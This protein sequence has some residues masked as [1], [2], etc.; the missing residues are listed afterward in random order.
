MLKVEVVPLDMADIVAE[1]LERLAPMIEEYRAEIILPDAW[2]AALG[3]GPWVVEVWANYVSN[4][5]KYGGTPPRVELG[6]TAQTDGTV[7][8]WVRDNGLGLS[9][10]EQGR[11]FTPFTRL[12]QDRGQGQTEVSAHRHDQGGEDQYVEMGEKMNGRGEEEYLPFLWVH[13]S[14]R[15]NVKAVPPIIDRLDGTGEGGI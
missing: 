8:F 12:H 4:A 15:C 3:Y 1:A 10:E 6:A 2:P 9:P 13:G 14:S 11:L 7:R 5:V